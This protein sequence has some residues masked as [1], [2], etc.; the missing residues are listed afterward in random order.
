MISLLPLS[1]STW[2]EKE[3]NAAC[4][5]IKSHRT[6]CGKLV[7]TFEQNFADFVGSKYCVMV[8]SGSSANL[9]AV[10]ALKYHVKYNNAHLGSVLLPALSWG[11]SY[12]P[13]AQNNIE[14][15]IHDIDTNL[16]NLD[17][18]TLETDKAITAAM[19]V[20]VLGNPVD[21]RVLMDKLNGAPMIEDCCE[22]LGAKY[23][24]RHVGTFGLAGTFSF[25]FSHHISTMEG[26]A[27]VTDDDSLYLILKSLRSHGWIRG[28]QPLQDLNFDPFMKQYTFIFPG[29]NLRPTEVQAAIGIEQLKKFKDFLKERRRNAN[30]VNNL[31]VSTKYP[32]I[33]EKVKLQE[34]LQYGYSSWFGFAFVVNVEHNILESRTIRD[35]LV[36]NLTNAGV[37][38]R[39]IL[40]GNIMNQPVLNHMK[41]RTTDCIWVAETTEKC[42]FYIGN[43][44][45]N[46]RDK[47]EIALEI[48]E[49]SL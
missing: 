39:P 17:V 41:F 15:M 35:T 25:F 6:T 27:I 4:N 34:E 14:L 2:D 10:E 1:T 13:W 45:L 22:A 21:M 44:H 26:G 48:I 20:H 33:K 11:T 38:C 12:F 23:D 49:R 31:V 7:E 16:L 28:I 9:L 24:G 36:N 5:V 29:Y 37:E 47:L 46:I 19:P 8:N 18:H 42:G 32:K 40:A 43:S 30:F 3:V